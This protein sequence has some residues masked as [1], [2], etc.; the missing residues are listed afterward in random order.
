MLSNQK[1]KMKDFQY[2]AQLIYSI[3]S[4]EPPFLS[5]IIVSI[6]PSFLEMMIDPLYKFM[7]YF[8][9]IIT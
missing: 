2:M 6:W 8:T 9:Y 7:A 5:D 1:Q 4:E 3:K